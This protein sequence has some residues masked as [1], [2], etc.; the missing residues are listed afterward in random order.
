MY[1][2]K[3]L[4][5]H[6]QIIIDI[7]SCRYATQVSVLH[8]EL[9]VINTQLSVLTTEI[10]ITHQYFISFLAKYSLNSV[11]IYIHNQ[12]IIIRRYRK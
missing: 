4:L 9:L 10:S 1:V 5:R 2:Q 8:T 12:R 7:E 11:E 3:S 6:R